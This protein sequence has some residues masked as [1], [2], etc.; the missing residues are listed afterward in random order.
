VAISPDGK[1]VASASGGDRTV[2]LWDAHNGKPLHDWLMPYRRIAPVL[3]TPDSANVIAA[4]HSLSGDCRM[5]DVA[6]GKERRIFRFPNLP[7]NAAEM[8]TGLRLSPNGEH[9]TAMTLGSETKNKIHV[10]KR[11]LTTWEVASG[12]RIGRR[13]LASNDRILMHTENLS[14]DGKYATFFRPPSVIIYD[15]QADR[16]WRSLTDADFG[17]IV[18]SSDSRFLAYTE[19]AVGKLQRLRVFDL[20]S[21][22]DILVL[23]TGPIAL[24]SF[25]PDSRYLLTVGDVGLRLWELAT[26]KEVLHHSP[27]TNLTYFDT[28]LAIAADGRSAAVGM[29]DTNV[30]VWDLAP[31]TRRK[32]K[33]NAGDLNRLWKELSGDDAPRAYQ[34]AGTLIADPQH[35][36]PFLRDHLKP[37]KEDAPRIRRL[38]ADLDS[39]QFAV[40]DAAFQ[41]L[42]KMDD[43]AH[44]VLRQELPKATS[45]ETRRRI[46]S[47]LSVPWVVRSPE[48]L[49]QIRAIMV[50]E[51]IGNADALRVLERL[52]DG[53][54]EARQTREAK[55]ALERLKTRR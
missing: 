2:R 24:R 16:P 13:P 17:P 54:L 42:E 5:W 36:V 34:S 23:D 28:C 48:K 1:Y 37:V 35:A 20:T 44:A 9:L 3:F 29:P 31:T 55:V 18:F 47:L 49:G 21:G 11:Y 43:A 6:S 14:P 40:R 10:W 46:Q 41:E 27:L 33:L 45:L 30:L 52:A 12:E 51:Q 4:P 39:E 53:S 32:M 50:L 19:R 25:S 7:K 15:L 22:T 26:G 8:L 38:I